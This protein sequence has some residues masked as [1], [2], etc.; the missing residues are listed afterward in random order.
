[1]QKNTE[2]DESSLSGAQI[3]AAAGLCAELGEE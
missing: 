1:M 3:R 2:F